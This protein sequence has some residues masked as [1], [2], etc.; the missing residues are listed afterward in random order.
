MDALP[1]TV[2]RSQLNLMLDGMNQASDELQKKHESGAFAPESGQ[3]TENLLL[4]GAQE[5]PKAHD[6][7]QAVQ[8][9]LQSKLN[10]WEG[11]PA[12]PQTVPLS[13]DSYQVKLLRMHLEQRGSGD[14]ADLQTLLEQLPEASPHE[15]S[16]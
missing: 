11:D 4:Y 13:L 14:R 3:Q 7:L 12:E 9:Q 5:F 2:T 10:S 16:D 1:L 15:D 8:V 6:R